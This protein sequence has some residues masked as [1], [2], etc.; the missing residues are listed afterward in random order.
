MQSSTGPRRKGEARPLPARNDAYLHLSLD[1]LRT[2]RCALDTEEGNVS[3]WRR[4]IQA[5]LDV[6]RAGR[7]GGQLDTDRLRPLLSNERVG[8]GRRALVSVLPDEGIPPLPSLAELWER[9][10]DDAD[11]AARD[12]FVGDLIAAEQQL[13]TYRSDLHRRI[14][15]ATGELI[16]RYREQPTLCLSVLPLGPAHRASA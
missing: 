16:A 10:V 3:Y 6:V 2:Y 13:S 14:A 7:S 4:I 11:N 1:A 9:S 5:R 12:A 15:N 8:V